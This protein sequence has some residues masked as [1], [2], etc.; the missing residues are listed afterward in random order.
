M[1]IEMKQNGIIADWQVTKPTDGTPWCAHD[2]HSSRSVYLTEPEGRIHHR[3]R[4]AEGKGKVARALV[5][6]LDGV[7]VYIKGDEIVVA[8]QAGNV[9]KMVGGVEQPIYET[10]VV[11]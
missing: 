8:R 5:V 11:I 7:A 3:T 1:I 6:E 2:K 4:E 9:K 10:S